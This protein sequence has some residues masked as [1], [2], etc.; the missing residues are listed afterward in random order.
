MELTLLQ[1]RVYRALYEKNYA[2]LAAG[3]GRKHMP[4]CRNLFL[5]LRKCCNHAYLIKGV[6]QRVESG[7]SAV[8]VQQAVGVD[9]A[10]A[11]PEEVATLRRH[12]GLILGS[13]K[14]VLLHKL[15][16]KLHDAG[17]K[18]LIFSQFSLVL[19]LIQVRKVV[20]DGSGCCGGDGVAG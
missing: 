10:T 5:E 18:V 15:L 9:P 11:A 8:D 14:M 3:V 12:A 4:N 16:P 6:E 13:G 20:C 7:M 1:K 17:S 19:D 2:Y